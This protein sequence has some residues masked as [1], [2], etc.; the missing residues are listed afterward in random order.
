MRQ[1]C[2]LFLLAVVLLAACTTTRPVSGQGS[3]PKPKDESTPPAVETGGF[4]EI[5]VNDNKAIDAYEFL[6]D[7]LA[8]S[9]PEISLVAAKRA[10]SQ[11]VAGFKIRLICAYRE[12]QKPEDRL[13]AI[14]YIDP[15]GDKRLLQLELTYAGD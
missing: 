8:V 10:F 6:E 7:Q 4:R 5:D 14:V 9:H 11:V 2:L 1:R 12:S 13:L 3:R 15:G